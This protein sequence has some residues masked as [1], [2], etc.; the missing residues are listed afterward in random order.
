MGKKNEDKEDA[1]DLV[2]GDGDNDS[3]DDSDDD[4]PDLVEG[5]FE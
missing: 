2:E 3:D 5:D 1:P 4:I